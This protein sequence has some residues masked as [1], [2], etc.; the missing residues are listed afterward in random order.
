MGVALS[1]WGECYERPTMAEAI[2]QQQQRRYE[3]AF[4]SAKWSHNIESV[5]SVKKVAEPTA[6]P[7][8]CGAEKDGMQGSS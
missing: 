1:I 3:V 5:S 2:Q 8:L 4:C 7:S 6:P